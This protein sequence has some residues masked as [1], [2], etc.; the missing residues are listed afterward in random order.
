MLLKLY[1]SKKRTLLFPLGQ[2]CI[3][4]VRVGLSLLWNQ[5]YWLG[6]AALLVLSSCVSAAW[7]KDKQAGNGPANQQPPYMLLQ[8]V[9]IPSEA[10]IGAASPT[11]WI[12]VTFLCRV[13]AGSAVLHVLI[14]TDI[15]NRVFNHASTEV[16]LIFFLWRALLCWWGTRMVGAWVKIQVCV[17]VWE[18]CDP[19]QP[20]WR[21]HPDTGWLSGWTTEAQRGPDW[22]HCMY[23]DDWRKRS[24]C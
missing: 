6:P 16:S 4:Q 20:G 15:W 8:H 13:K 17:A 2:K 1:R 10:Y 24:F 3:F 12:A 22:C 18:E 14:S 5:L 11:A 23:T 9:A 19:S 7:T 21:E